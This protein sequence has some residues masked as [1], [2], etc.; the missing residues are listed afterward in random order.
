MG[1]ESLLPVRSRS[2]PNRAGRLSSVNN[3]GGNYNY[4]ALPEYYRRL[5][6]AYIEGAR[7]RPEE[8]AK[9]LRNFVAKTAKGQRIGYVREFR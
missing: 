6:I 8:F 4:Q 5:R 3:L 9:R 2:T 7:K 1:H